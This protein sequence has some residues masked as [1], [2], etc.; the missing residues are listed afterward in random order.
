VSDENSTEDQRDLEESR[1][2]VRDAERS[3][4]EVED[5][6]ESLHVTSE[7]I[8]LVV[9]RNGYVDRFRRVLRGV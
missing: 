1:R 7:K 9:E 3:S 6:L 4:R 5:A 8:R 2:A